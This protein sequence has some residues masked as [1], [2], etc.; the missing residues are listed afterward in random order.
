VLRIG[1][2]APDFS[3]DTSSGRIESFHKTIGD[4]WAVLMSHPR[5]FTPVCTTERQWQ[6]GSARRRGQQLCNVRSR[7]STDACTA[8][9]CISFLQWAA[10]RS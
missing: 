4:G 5:D 8:V 10:W 7:S 3:A 6:G 2:T 9:F 1:D